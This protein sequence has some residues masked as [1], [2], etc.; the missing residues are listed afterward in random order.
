[1]TKDTDIN[2]PRSPRSRF[3]FVGAVARTFEFLTRL[4]FSQAETSPTLVRYRKDDIQAKVYYGR[5]SYE[6]GFEIGHKGNEYSIS[7]LI[8]ATDPETARQYR[9][10]IATSQ[11]ALTEGLARLEELTRIY[12]LR[13]LQGDP[14]FFVA[15]DRQRKSWAEAYALEVLESQL[16]PKADEAFRRGDYGEAVKLY[17][18]IRSRLSPADLKKLAIA[19]ERDRR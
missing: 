5:Q 2:H 15:L 13:G 1:M 9:N 19:K 12:G 3:D 10:P 6:L 18:R 11:K 17:E 7:E 4:G 8:R 14:E 16:R